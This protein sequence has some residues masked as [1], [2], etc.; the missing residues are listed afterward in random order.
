MKQIV[1]IEKSNSYGNLDKMLSKFIVCQKKDLKNKDLSLFSKPIY[2][3]NIFVLT[4][5]L[6]IE[7]NLQIK[8]STK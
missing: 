1:I 5:A 2:T 7:K 4:K 8:R 3:D 6:E